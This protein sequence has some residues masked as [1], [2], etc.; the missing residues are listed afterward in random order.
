MKLL[1]DLCSSNPNVDENVRACLSMIL[2]D[3]EI[4]ANLVTAHQ[5]LVTLVNEPEQ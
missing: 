2:P 1:L 4:P 5:A 3:H